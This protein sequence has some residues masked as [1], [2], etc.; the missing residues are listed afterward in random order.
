MKKCVIVEDP[1]LTKVKVIDLWLS[2]ADMAYQDANW[3]RKLDRE[4]GLKIWQ[5]HY[6]AL[7]WFNSPCKKVGSFVWLCEQILGV[8]PETIRNKVRALTISQGQRLHNFFLFMEA[9]ND[10]FESRRPTPR[11]LQPTE[12]F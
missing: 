2:V 6:P 4:F 5:R 7:S 11:K 12:D 3:K 1:L 8:E 10:N 9:L